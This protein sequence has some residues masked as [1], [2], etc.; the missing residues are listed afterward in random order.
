M[1]VLSMTTS[2]ENQVNY[3]TKLN[4]KNKLLKIRNKM[5]QNV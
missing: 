3:K 2:L 4:G 1:T 5:K